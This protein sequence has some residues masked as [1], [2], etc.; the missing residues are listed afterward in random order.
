MKRLV[1][2]ALLLLFTNAAC[3][4]STYDSVA[5]AVDTARAQA[6]VFLGK[7]RYET[8]A[9]TSKVLWHVPSDMRATV[10][11]FY[12]AGTLQSGLIDFGSTPTYAVLSAP[13]GR[14][15]RFEIKRVVIGP[16][17]YIDPSSEIIMKPDSSCTTKD[18]GFQTDIE[19][20]LSL[21][22]SASEF[23][24]GRPFSARR[25]CLK[26][27]PQCFGGA[28]PPA[29]TGPVKRIRMFTTTDQDGNPTDEAFAIRLK[30]NQSIA[31]PDSNFITLD[32]NSGASVRF[33]DYDVASQEGKGEF[34]KVGF[35]V[36]KSVLTFG[37][38]VLNLTAGSFISFDNFKIGVQAEKFE[39]SDGTISGAVGDNSQI[40]L[41][42]NTGIESSLF[43]QSADLQL[44]GV[45]IQYNGKTGRLSGT[46][47]SFALVTRASRLAM[48]PNT[49]VLLQSANL[50]LNLAC[51]AGAS[52]GCL[53]FVWSSD[54]GVVVKGT[55]PAAAVHLEQGGYLALPGQN[56]LTIEGGEM[57]TDVLTVDSENK[58]T[59]IRGK[60][61]NLKLRLAAQDWIFDSNTRLKAATFGLWTTSLEVLENDPFPVGAVNVDATVTE[62]TAKGLGNVRFA[63]GSGKILAKVMREAGDDPKLEG[64][65]SGTVAA[66]GGGPDASARVTVAFN[67]IRYYRGYGSAKFDFSVDEATAVYRTPYEERDEG[68]PG[69]K[70][71]IKAPSLPITMRLAAKFGFQNVD[72][73][74]DKGDWTMANV[75]NVPLAI[76]VSLPAMTAAKAQHYF[77]NSTLGYTSTSCRPEVK[78]VGAT[79]RISGTA[80]LKFG[81]KQKQ[82]V[83]RG[84]TIDRPLEAD[85]DASDCKVVAFISCGVIGSMLSPTAGV[86]AALACGKKVDEAKQQF[87]ETI[88]DKTYEFV[89]QLNFTLAL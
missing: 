28:T 81:E 79:Y 84:F 77:G 20:F 89:Q 45:T 34:T 64:S 30:P 51:A 67:D 29:K 58:V 32:Q 83:T 66:T 47:G 38:T 7:G 87:Q 55:I 35:A 26:G 82:I 37:G 27:T 65:V 72:L 85:L 9:N 57:L 41:A 50:R 8:V 54:G 49:L 76:D 19:A 75:D 48:S 18:S 80:D 62:F 39:M 40:R 46:S 74:V 60:M 68:V 1:Q 86:V 16:G 4:S 21:N 25:M 12:G 15:T 36:K 71:E 33:I 61:Q 43:I 56:K 69:G 3:A 73:K 42:S 53:P 31:F 5:N 13:D 6:Y 44:N 23:F 24:S 88:R 2:Y 59:P 14:C 10:R 11:F 63:S 52:A 22:P 17:G 70:F 78:A